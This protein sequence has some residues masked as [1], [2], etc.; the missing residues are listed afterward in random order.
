MEKYLRQFAPFVALVVAAALVVIADPADKI[1]SSSADT[2]QVQG[3]QASRVGASTLPSGAAEVPVGADA[4]T[5]AEPFAL[6]SG[7]SSG[8]FGSATPSFS[9]GSASDFATPSGGS[10]AEAFPSGGSSA[11]VPGS[12]SSPSFDLPSDTTPTTA[13]PAGEVVG[14]SDFFLFS[15]L[16]RS[17]ACTA[18]GDT[19]KPLSLADGFSQAVVYGEPSFP[20]RVHGQTFNRTDPNFERFVYRAHSLQSNASVSFTDTANNNLTGILAQRSDWERLDGITWTPTGNQIITGE[21]VRTSELK[22]PAATTA[23]AGMAYQIN[24]NTGVSTLLPRLGSRAHKGIAFDHLGYIYGVSSTNPGYLY[25]YVP[26]AAG[27]YGQATGTG[28]L[29]ALWIGSNGESQ[30]LPLDMTL[31]QTDADEA[32]RQ[33]GATALLTPEDVEPLIITAP[34]GAKR[35]QLFVAE[36]GANRVLTVVLRGS[37]STAFTS[38]YVA[39]GVNA[40]KDFS[41]PADLAIDTPY[42]LYIAERNGGGSA[43]SKSSGDD[44]WVA[45]A[46]PTSAIFA[47]AAGRLASV[48]DCDAEP[49]GLMFD[50]TGSK[51]YMNLKHRGGDG[52]DLTLLVTKSGGI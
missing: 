27:D 4:G 13:A 37:D 33:V 6:P 30:W 36:S 45:P 18:G 15:A 9:S 24:P 50:G 7:S 47:L 34:S 28:K 40:P 5:A 38:T 46:N 41:A 10:S 21:N 48:T 8:G 39:P 44:I 22:D 16:D 3:A 32:A 52:R 31:V 51:L 25:R 12:S 20:D 11:A 49:A 14:A 23:K 1:T 19:V 2:T 43:E 17:A 29:Y 26:G 35:T 42:S